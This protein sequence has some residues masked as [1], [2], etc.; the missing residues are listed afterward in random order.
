MTHPVTSRVMVWLADTGDCKT[1]A[2][3][4]GCL[5]CKKQGFKNVFGKFQAEP[6]LCN[7]L[8]H[9]NCDQH[10]AAVEKFEAEGEKVEDG[11]QQKE[12]PAMAVNYAHFIFQRTLLSTA[13]SFSN[14]QSWVKSAQ[15]TGANIPDGAIGPQVSRQL[16]AVMAGREREVTKKLLT[17]CAACALKQDGR[18]DAVAVDCK[19]VLWRWPPGL[20]T[21]PPIH[22]LKSLNNGK[23][24][25]VACRFAVLTELGADHG[26][27]ALLH[28]FESV[29]SK[30][31]DDE[32]HLRSLAEKVRFLI[33]DGARDELS[34]G[35]KFM[36]QYP[37]TKFH[38]VDECHTAML[39]LKKVLAADP[40]IELV[41]R[42]LVSGKKPYSV[43][44]WLSTSGIASSYFK[45]E[46]RADAVA[47]LENLSW[48]MQRF[49]SRKRP[50]SRICLRLKQVFGCLASLAE[51]KQKHASECK[52]LLESLSGPHTNRLVLAAMLADV[53]WEHSAWVHSGDYND[54]CPVALE[55][56][57]EKFFLRCSSWDPL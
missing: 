42:L 5:I 34:A 7:I 29:L 47:V 50:L 12:V 28:S 15:L 49:D 13:S 10:K 44:K 40:E 3:H 21:D 31:A 17:H 27:D 46:E 18:G 38:L 37:S 26:A 52:K 23:A 19:L 32:E 22:G 36:A 6:K 57:Q 11:L 43:A 1:K 4:I 14:F 51:S 9:A 24:P 33:T 20:P 8:R 41:E 39:A 55:A 30:H 53:A 56:A 16:L 45:D 2:W 54:P 48:A 25:W 35:R